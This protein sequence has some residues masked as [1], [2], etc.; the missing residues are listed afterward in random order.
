MET[1]WFLVLVVIGVLVFS[2]GVYAQTAPTYLA[3]G[4]STNPW[5]VPEKQAPK[6]KQQPSFRG[7]PQNQNQQPNSEQLNYRRQDR[8]VTPEILE[9]LKQQQT[10]NQ[11]TPN[12]QYYGDNRS[13]QMRPPQRPQQ[14]PQ[15]YG[16]PSY[17]MGYMQPMQ[18]V[19]RVS[20]WA[21]TPDILY[22]GESFP[23]VPDEAIGGLPP[24]QMPLFGTDGANDMYAPGIQQQNKGFNP[25]TFIPNGDLQ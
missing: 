4:H 16:V 21:N 2:K 14:L 22:Q 1:Y 10:N 23:M 7:V 18:D 12:N 25:F 13:R 9:S 15:Q 20:P 17:G 3:Q 19:P 5:A 8:F 24:M 6:Q 11:L